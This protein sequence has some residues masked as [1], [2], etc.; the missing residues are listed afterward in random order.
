MNIKRSN[1]LWRWYQHYGE[2]NGRT[3]SPENLCRFVRVCFFWAP[4]RFFFSTKTRCH[5]E[6]ISPFFALIILFMAAIAAYFVATAIWDEPLGALYW[7]VSSIQVICLVLVFSIAGARG[8]EK[9][10]D[11]IT[12]SESYRIAKTSGIC[13]IITVQDDESN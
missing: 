2:L 5:N 13:P 3:R 9:L 11:I 4:I 8:T 6:R 10:H 12:L 1:W 7:A